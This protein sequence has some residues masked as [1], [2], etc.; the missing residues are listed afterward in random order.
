MPNFTQHIGEGLANF[1]KA[2]TA[3]GKGGK[4]KTRKGNFGSDDRFCSP[5][6]LYI[7]E[8]PN[9]TKESTTN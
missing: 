6:L 8:W 4:A 5:F 2:T 9:M 1:A 3:Q 7:G